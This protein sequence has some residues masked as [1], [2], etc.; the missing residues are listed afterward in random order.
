MIG[1]EIQGQSFVPIACD[2]TQILPA[3]K[4]HEFSG[5]PI[6]YR[7]GGDG[8]A[9][10]GHRYP[11]PVGEDRFSLFPIKLLPEALIKKPLRPLVPL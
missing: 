4:T 10:Y 6:C 5:T 3:Q 2:L 1:A 9:G 7:T 11:L 8:G